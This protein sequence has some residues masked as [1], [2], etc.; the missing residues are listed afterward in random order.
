M[1]SL[2]DQIRETYDRLT[3]AWKSND[4][5]AVAGFFTEEGS[6]VNPSAPDMVC[7]ASAK[8][9][10]SPTGRSELHGRRGPAQHAA[11][12]LGVHGSDGRPPV[13]ALAE[14]TGA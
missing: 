1:S 5:A 10:S 3:T 9:W 7:S 8:A 2:T 12:V 6:L 14:P 13:S 11:E 4:G